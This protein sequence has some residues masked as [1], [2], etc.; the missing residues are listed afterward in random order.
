MKRMAIAAVGIVVLGALAACAA[1]GAG[2]ADGAAAPLF[3]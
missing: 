2:Q 1:P 3:E